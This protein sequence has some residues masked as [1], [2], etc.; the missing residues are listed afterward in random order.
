MITYAVSPSQPSLSPLLWYGLGL[1]LRTHPHPAGHVFVA[2]DVRGHFG[3][4]AFQF[5]HHDIFS[6]DSV[7]CHILGPCTMCTTWLGGLL[8][9][10]SARKSNTKIPSLSP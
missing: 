10:A 2:Q 4:L 3:I 1:R 8:F 5:H 7:L 6:M 9:I